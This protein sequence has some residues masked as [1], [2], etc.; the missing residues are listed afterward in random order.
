MRAFRDPFKPTPSEFQLVWSLL[1]EAAR[2]EFLQ[3]LRRM[4]EENAKNKDP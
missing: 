2:Q 4:S 1:S 3:E